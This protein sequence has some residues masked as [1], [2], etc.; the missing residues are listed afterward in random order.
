MITITKAMDVGA[1]QLQIF[2]ENYPGSHKF[3]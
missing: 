3:Y 1:E 2:D